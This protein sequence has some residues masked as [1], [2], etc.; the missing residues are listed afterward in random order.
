MA[1][2]SKKT[3]PKVT[4]RV[5]ASLACLFLEFRRIRAEKDGG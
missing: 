4:D 5:V 1:F 2:E 3:D